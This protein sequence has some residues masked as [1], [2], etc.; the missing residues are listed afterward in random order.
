MVRLVRALSDSAE[1][2]GD[3]SSVKRMAMAQCLNLPSQHRPDL[4]DSL[5]G[6]DDLL[7][8]L[9]GVKI[10]EGVPYIYDAYMMGYKVGCEPHMHVDTQP[11]DLRICIKLIANDTHASGIRVHDRGEVKEIP[12]GNGDAVLFTPSTGGYCS[13]QCH[14][15]LPNDSG[16]V[17]ATL[18]VDLKFKP[19]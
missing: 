14:Q 13:P 17:I 1:R 5:G 11:Y 3:H 10:P 19:G 2:W 4:K 9:V 15:A 12:L 8:M 6:V 18:V 7:A 16:S